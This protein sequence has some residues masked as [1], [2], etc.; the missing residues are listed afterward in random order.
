MN[1][2]R[3]GRA[4]VT[5]GSA[6]VTGS[7]TR[8]LN[9]IKPGDVFMYESLM[10]TIASVDDHHQLTLSQPWAGDTEDLIKYQ[11][12]RLPVTIGL[13][14]AKAAAISEVDALAG[15]KRMQ[16]ITTSPGQDVTY[17]S[18]LEDARAYVAAG[19]PQDS[20][21]F[22]WIHAEATATGSTA[23]Q[24]ADFIIV[25]AE[26]WSAVGAQIEGARQG[27]KQAINAVTIEQGV[28]AVTDAVQSFKSALN[29]I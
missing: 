2:H 4:N 23:Q 26:L 16:Y 22:V 5:N 10:V 11:I 12:D 27:A 29:A 28:E 24:T 14:D 3:A 7:G 1:P 19:Y 15:K 17:L 18:K 8:W 25:T 20:T 9:Y 6:I 13:D 21:P